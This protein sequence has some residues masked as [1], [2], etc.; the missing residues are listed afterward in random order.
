M[1]KS[2]ID[3]LKRSIENL[4]GEALRKKDVIDGLEIEKAECE[5]DIAL[6]IDRIEELE[7][8]VKQL[9]GNSDEQTPPENKKVKRKGSDSGLW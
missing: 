8:T 3:I 4:K 7:Q 6:L 9:E 1:S 2:A 5:A